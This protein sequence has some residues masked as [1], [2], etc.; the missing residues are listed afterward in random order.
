MI[1]ILATLLCVFAIAAFATV[2]LRAKAD[3]ED[4]SIEPDELH[5]LLNKG[6]ILLF[7]V[8]QPLDVLTYPE[9]IPGAIRIPP[10]DAAALSASYSR[11]EEAVLYCTG[12]DDKTGVMVLGK[13]RAL[14]FTRVKL[15]KGGLQAWK[16]KGYPVEQYTESFQL[17]VLGPEPR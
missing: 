3:L 6:E 10:K 15:L 9:I 11:D 1:A 2:R 16:Q 4:N 5:A 13:V 12:V 14:N 8:R 17:D 7:D